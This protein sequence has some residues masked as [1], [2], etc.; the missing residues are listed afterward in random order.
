MVGKSVG[1]LTRVLA[2]CLFV[3]VIL[4]R[5]ALCDLRKLV[6]K[7]D[8]I[9]ITAVG[10]PA[11]MIM[12]K[13]A[14]SSYLSGWE[15]EISLDITLPDNSVVIGRVKPNGDTLQAIVPASAINSNPN[16]SD[17]YRVIILDRTDTLETT[18]ALVHEDYLPGYF[19]S[20][21]PT[22]F[23]KKRYKIWTDG[24]PCKF[25]LKGVTRLP[26]DGLF[27]LAANDWIIYM[28][29]SAGAIDGKVAEEL[30]GYLCAHGE[31]Q[32]FDLCLYARLLNGDL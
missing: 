15:C 26:G 13:S 32:A 2:L 27:N 30:F 25:S 12:S 9:Y 3:T 17:G 16:A 24:L 1:N 14:M 11:T 18:T 23:P 20:L 21:L 29:G 22:V 19:K 7:S 6:D 31:H 10:A 8:G 28:N 5:N 4:G